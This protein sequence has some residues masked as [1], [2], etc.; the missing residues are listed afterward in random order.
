M[1]SRATNSLTLPLP[2][3]LIKNGIKLFL[4]RLTISVTAK[5]FSRIY[6]T[7]LPDYQLEKS[8]NKLILR[9]ISGL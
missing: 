5:K 2:I 3:K 7:S 4:K 9:Y 1:E 8:S 6:R